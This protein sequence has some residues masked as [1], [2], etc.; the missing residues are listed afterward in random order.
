MIDMWPCKQIFHTQ[1]SVI[2]GF[3]APRIKLKL[4]QQMDGGTTNSKPPGRIIMM[5]QSENT[6]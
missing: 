5:G 2:Y 1:S 6:Q 4:R 3:A